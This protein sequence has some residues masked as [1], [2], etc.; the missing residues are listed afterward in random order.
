MFPVTAWLA[1]RVFRG[2]LVA[3]LAPALLFVILFQITSAHG[4]L[5]TDMTARIGA[6]QTIPSF[7]LGAALHRLASERPAPRSWV[8]PI[9]G[10][11]GLWI[12][13]ATSLRL[14]DLAIWPAFAPLVW[15]VA[16]L[17]GAEGVSNASPIG[18]LSRLSWALVLTY[19][20]VDIVYFHAVDRLLGTPRGWFAWLVWA[21]VF[22]T[23][24]LVAALAYAFVQRPCEAWLRTIDPFKKDR[25]HAPL[26]ARFIP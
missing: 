11:C 6:V 2:T 13:V 18:E 8:T 12:V 20:P 4:V 22:P 19:L 23:V 5:F 16:S 26:R 25:G 24:L 10:L 3:L 21:G 1:E 9:L 14:S 7:L 15:A 17:P